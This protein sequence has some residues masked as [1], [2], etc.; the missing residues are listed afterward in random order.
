MFD[1]TLTEEQLALQR[2][3]RDFIKREIEPVAKEK[4]A[5]EDPLK[6]MPWD[7]IV[8]LSKLGIRTLALKKEYGGAGADC[9][10]CCIVI[11]ELSVGELGISTLIAQTLKFTNY[12]NIAM[13]DEQRARFLPDFIKDDTYLLATGTTE[14]DTDKGFRYFEP[15][16]LPGTGV[17]TNAK[18]DGKGGWVIN[19]LKHYISTGSDAKLYFIFARTD[20]TKGGPEGVTVF[21][22]PRGTPGFTTGRIEDKIGQ[23]LINNAELIFENCRVPDENILIG[24]GE[25]SKVRNTYTQK[26]NVEAG[27]TALGTGRAAYEAALDW[28]K[29][30]V[31]GGK[32]IIQHEAIGVMLAEMAASLEAARTLTW[33]AAWSV[34]HP[35][36]AQRYLED[37]KCFD[38]A[39]DIKKQNSLT[40]MAKFFTTEATVEV[41]IKAMEILGGHGIMRD[42]PTEKCLR[43]S[44]TF[45]HSDRTNIMH[46]LSTAQLIGGY[47][48]RI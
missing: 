22:V 37:Y 23:R 3:I 38:P 2:L 9:L 27:A 47:E 48:V 29:T 45:L 14:P 6:R 13:N 25:A 16:N 33:K 5:I 20:P 1:F 19:G 43:D 8:K 12:F 35:E 31:Q 4:E 17:R 10:T 36:E 46:R 28:A 30:R 32:P 24:E 11:E 44:I 41:V 40:S 42:G 21:I 15:S 18:R 26:S 7:I 34:D 39:F